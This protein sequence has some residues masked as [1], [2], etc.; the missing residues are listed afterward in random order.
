MFL[1]RSLVLQAITS[2]FIQPTRPWREVA[3]AI[4]GVKPIVET[5]RVLTNQPTPKR[6]FLPAET[7]L[8]MSRL[9]EVP[10]KDSAGTLFS[11]SNALLL[12]RVL[13]FA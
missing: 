2:F 6:Q 5:W 10:V 9:I 7:L 4:V 12:A 8:S 13:I 11:G 3:Y 1:D